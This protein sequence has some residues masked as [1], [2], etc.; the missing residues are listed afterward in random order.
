MK[1][2]GSS[3]IDGWDFG[4][5]FL[6]GKSFQDENKE[7]F[8]DTIAAGTYYV[9]LWLYH[10]EGFVFANGLSIT[11]D[12]VNPANV[13]FSPSTVDENCIIVWVKYD[14]SN[15]DHVHTP[16]TEWKFNTDYHWHECV[17]NDGQQF[18]KAKHIYDNACDKDCNEC[19]ATRTPAAHAYVNACDKDCNVCGAVR[20]PAAHVYDNACDADCSVCG[21]ARTVLDHKD[22]NE[23]GK[24]DSCGA[25]IPGADPGP[26]P[27]PTPTPDPKP[28]KN[29]LSGG[30]I[31]AIVIGATVVLASGGFAIYWFV[32]QKKSVEDLVVLVKKTFAPETTKDIP[33]ANTEDNS[34]KSPE[35]NNE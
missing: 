11:V 29:G 24:C 31:A 3:G 30:A 14:V 32:I 27:T 15:P 19:G 5:V 28:E 6:D 26:A 9:K 21:F 18:N 13:T 33:E 25:D 2:N 12:G 8:Y 23:N 35:E 7:H 20:T 16:N 34:E 17:G 10:N 4:D 1:I 22:E